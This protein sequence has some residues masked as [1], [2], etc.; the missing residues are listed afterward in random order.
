MPAPPPLFPE[1][2]TPLEGRSLPA[3]LAGV[4]GAPRRLHLH[5]SLAGGPAVAIVGAR[6]ASFAGRVFARHLGRALAREGLHVVSGGA[7]GIDT[8]AHE[9]AMAGGGTTTIVAP[10]GWER[11]FPAVN[12]ELFR[13]VVRCGGG[14]LSVRSPAD[15]VV[16]GAFLRRNL[17]LAALASALVIVE[18]RDHSGAR[19]AARCARK[20][21]RPVFAVPH[22]PWAAGGRGCVL[23]L[24]EGACVAARASDVL[25]AL[26]G[27]LRDGS[28]G[29]LP[30]PAR[31]AATEAGLRV[32]SAL[33]RGARDADAIATG[34][35][36]AHGAVQLALVELTLAG[37]VTIDAAGIPRRT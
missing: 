16:R 22:A 2:G 32:L 20:L 6:R 7:E 37:A 9:G 36:L 28:P 29:T 33:D 1:L 24:R 13:R 27:I 34:S 30:D 23:E 15:G 26:A 8:A 18:A 31:G 35:G 3:R 5:G 14:Y 12:A 17:V 11:P 4:A 25:E 19:H 10:G 21:G